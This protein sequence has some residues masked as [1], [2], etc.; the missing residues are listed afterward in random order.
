MFGTLKEPAEKKEK[1]R[2]GCRNFR[3]LNPLQKRSKF[4]T[5]WWT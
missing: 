2:A 3:E 5:Y 1:I 4:E